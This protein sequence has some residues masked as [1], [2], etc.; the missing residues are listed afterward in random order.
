MNT[1]NGAQ[2]NSRAGLDMRTQYSE[3][4]NLPNPDSP[5]ANTLSNNPIYNMLQVLFDGTKTEA[6][7][8]GTPENA[9]I[10]SN[11]LKNSIKTGWIG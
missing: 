3:I 4:N 7:P 8:H 5:Q 9:V 2:L 10:G 1:L 6:M 11:G